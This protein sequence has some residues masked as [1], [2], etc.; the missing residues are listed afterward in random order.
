MPRK[1]A[2]Q[3]KSHAKGHNRNTAVSRDVTMSKSMSSF[4]KDKLPFS[5]RFRTKMACAF[6][7]TLPSSTASNGYFYVSGNSA[8]TPFNS[9]QAYATRT[10]NYYSATGYSGDS[11]SAVQPEGFSAIC[12]NTSVYKAYRVHA[13]KISV[14][15]N[16]TSTADNLFL[17]INAAQT[18]TNSTTTIWTSSQSPFSTKLATFTSI[19]QAR[20]V[21]KLLNT[22]HV[23]GVPQSAIS[24]D[25]GFG[26]SYNGSPGNEWCWV[27]QWQII[28][29]TATNAVM[30]VRVELEYDI[31]FYSP[32]SGALP[33]VLLHAVNKSSSSA[34][35]HPSLE[36]SEDET[37]T[38]EYVPVLSVAEFNDL[39]TE[40]LI[41]RQTLL[42]RE[43]KITAKPGAGST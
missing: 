3:R 32:A 21:T 15:L 17:S 7:G 39:S 41:I 9:A 5:P 30:G 10:I 34:A 36:C 4:S 8:H 23:W 33:D 28:D 26:A 18:G 22:H 2:P 42:A 31:E 38:D 16:P 19:E 1:V 43:R 40:E 6:I 11:Y 29:N 37:S 24:V 14:S 25:D 27:V 12:S 13:S 35:P 20:P